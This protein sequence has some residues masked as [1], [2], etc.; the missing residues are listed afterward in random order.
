M[1]ELSVKFVGFAE[2]CPI[3]RQAIFH[4]RVKALA[5]GVTPAKLREGTLTHRELQ[6][7][8]IEIPATEQQKLV[9]ALH[10]WNNSG[11]EDHL[12]RFNP[13]VSLVE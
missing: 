13:S 5:D 2:G 4:V 1:T 8:G 11:C 7:V 12:L 10:T 6:Q 9:D 3:E